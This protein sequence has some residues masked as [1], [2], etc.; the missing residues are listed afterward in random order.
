YWGQMIRYL[1]RSRLGDTSDALLTVDR[2]RYRVGESVSIRA[3]FPGGM[4]TGSKDVVVTLEHE[5]GTRRHVT[6]Q[7]VSLSEDRFQV[8]LDDL[9][10]GSYHAWL[11]A[12]VSAKMPPGI[13]FRVEPPDAES[14]AVRA[15]VEVMQ[16]A[17]ERS[18]G[19]L[20]NVR[21]LESLFAK[22][23]EGT[24][25]PVEALPPIGLWNRWPILLLVIG[26]LATEWMLRKWAGLP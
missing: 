1:C 22:L 11:S 26:L 4:P 8:V 20:G 3:E 2:E 14:A 13:D 24:Q 25:V 12:P 15:K 21:S 5:D 23:P 9:P 10:I 17:A 7:R 18:G 16:R 19:E 6:A